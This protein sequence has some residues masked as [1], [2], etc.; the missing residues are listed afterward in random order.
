MARMTNRNGVR[1]LTK[2]ELREIRRVVS[3]GDYCIDG[4]HNGEPFAND[5]T[6]AFVEREG[7]DAA[8]ELCEYIVANPDTA[9][10]SPAASWREE[11]AW[12]LKRT[13]Y[14]F[15]MFRLWSRNRTVDVHPD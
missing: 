2:D 14:Y 13:G 11:D 9:F 12:V 3:I 7:I 4:V 8:D 5:K 15:K 1:P 6:R 10:F